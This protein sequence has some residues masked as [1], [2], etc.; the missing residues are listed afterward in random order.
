MRITLACPEGLID[1]AK[2]LAMVTG[3]SAADA[4]TFDSVEWEDASGNRYSAASILVFGDYIEKAL[5]AL[6]RPEWDGDNEVNMAA[7]Q[8][9]QAVVDFHA[10]DGETPTPQAAPDKITVVLG[11]DT[12][13]SLAAMGLTKI[14]VIEWHS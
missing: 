8:R 4:D 9:A 7:A 3:Y 6:E 5:S 10:P 2:H 1:D 14:E 13:A 11:D 12:L